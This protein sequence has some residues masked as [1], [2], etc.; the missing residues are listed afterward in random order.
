MKLEET[1]MQEVVRESLPRK[2]GSAPFLRKWQCKR[3]SCMYRVMNSHPPFYFLVK[4]RWT[5]LFTKIGK[6]HRLRYI[7]NNA[8]VTTVWVFLEL[9]F[10]LWCQDTLSLILSH[11]GVC[12]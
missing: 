9:Y 10:L 11:L 12:E 1:E 6:S 4:I 5:G 7:G 3:D 2:G 8:Q